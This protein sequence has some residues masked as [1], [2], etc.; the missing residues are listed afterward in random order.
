[1]NHPLFSFV[2]IIGISL[3]AALTI[4]FLVLSP[5]V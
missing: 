3:A 5:T 1:M 4:Y 2:V